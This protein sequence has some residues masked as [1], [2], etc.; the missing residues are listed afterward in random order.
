MDSSQSR[1]KQAD[2]CNLGLTEWSTKFQ[3]N[4]WAFV[5]YT[6]HS[7]RVNTSR[8][9]AIEPNMWSMMRYYLEAFNAS[10]MELAFEGRFN[11][12]Y[13]ARPPSTSVLRAYEAFG[14][15]S[16]PLTSPDLFPQALL[17]LLD[18]IQLKQVQLPSR[19]LQGT[20]FVLPNTFTFLVFDSMPLGSRPYVPIV[21][22][23]DYALMLHQLAIIESSTSKKGLKRLLAEKSA[24]EASYAQKWHACDR[25]RKFKDIEAHG[26][27]STVVYSEPPLDHLC[28]ECNRHGHHYR[29]AC[30]LWPKD[31]PKFVMGQ[32]GC[33]KFGAKRA[34]EATDPLLYSLIHKK[35][36]T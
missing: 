14:Q 25:K 16:R 27:K 5:A 18:P 28:V 10:N 9:Y 33:K 32:F 2:N 26:V 7:T 21:E 1:L 4:K 31:A 17:N 24:L 13:D 20:D 35:H 36:T 8:W 11:T 19:E 12:H 29:E 15:H 6:G 34:I 3:E 22:R 23:S 30:F